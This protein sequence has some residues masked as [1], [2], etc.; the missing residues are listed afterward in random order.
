MEDFENKYQITKTIRFKLEPE[1]KIEN[2]FKNNIKEKDLSL[3]IKQ[4]EELQNKLKKLLHKGK[5]EDCNII[6]NSDGSTAWKCNIEIKYTWM[7]NYLKV[8]F[9]ENLKNTK[10]KHY[11]LIDLK[12]VQEE[13][14]NRWFSET[15]EILNGLKDFQKRVQYYTYEKERDAQAA[16]ILNQFSKRTNFEFIKMFIYSLCNTNN[17]KTD[18]FIEKLKEDIKALEIELNKQKENFLPSQSKGVQFAIGSFNYYTIGKTPKLLEKELQK[19]NEKLNEKLYYFDEKY[20]AYKIKG[21]YRKYESTINVLNLKLKQDKGGI[22]ICNLSL[23]E[24]YKFLKNWKAEQKQNF[25]EAIK[26]NDDN[27][28]KSIE[29]FKSTDDHYETVKKA[30]LYIQKNG[31]KNVSDEIK[32]QIR[33]FFDTF[34]DNPQTPNYKKLCE[35]FRD[36]AKDRGNIVAKI[37][38]IE[39]DKNIAEQLYYWCVII[40]K[41]K[42]KYLYMIPHD[43]NDNLKKAKEYIEKL[44]SDN[45]S[46]TKLHYF[47]SLTLRALRKL[48]FKTKDNTFRGLIPNTVSFPNCEQDWKKE[49]KKIIEFYQQVL[50]NQK[51]INLDFYNNVSKLWENK[52]DTL[53]DFES[54]LNKIC[55]SKK[56]YISNEVENKLKKDFKAISFKITS[57]DIEH[58]LKYG[59]ENYQNKKHTDIWN[60]FWNKDNENN[61]YRVRLNPEVKV[62]W[63]LPKERLILKYGIDSKL[64]DEKKKNR[65]LHEQYTLVTTI[66]SNAY[67]DKINFAFKD[68]FKETNVKETND[69]SKETAINK[70]NENFKYNKFNY[71]IGIDVGEIS[72]A[73]LAV[74]NKE[75]KSQIFEVYEI[76]EEKLNF[77]KKGFLKDGSIREKEYQL[78]QNPSYF[79]N[80]VLYKKTFKEETDEQF[81]NTFKELFNKKTVSG[82]DLTTAKVICDKIILN[83]DFATH[84]RLKELNAKR[85]ISQALK[86]YQNITIDKA[87]DKDGKEKEYALALFGNDKVQI[88]KT[89]KEAIYE[90]KKNYS[91]VKS[92]EEVK[93]ELIKFLNDKQ[94]DDARLEDN[95]NKTRTSLVGNMVGVINFLYKKYPGFIVLE[96]LKQTNTES[97]RRDFEG[98]ITRPL[99]WALYRKFQTEC[100]VPPISELIKLRELNPKNKQNIHQFGII[101]FV[102]E[103]GT[104][105]LCPKCGEKVYNSDMSKD[106]D[107]NKDKKNKVFK[108][109]KCGFNNKT[110]AGEFMGLDTNDTIAA[111]NIAKRGFA[112][113]D[114]KITNKKND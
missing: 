93:E 89:G 82:L 72:L 87:K 10:S 6:K 96:N 15:T 25:I 108:C 79:L 65:Y 11:K 77:S 80:P 47:N 5:K 99:E 71:A 112:N 111:Y 110:D 32:K 22:D 31:K 97:H 66:T 105:L 12:Y 92:F 95:I 107:Y 36:I 57:Q 75:N 90:S 54:E 27:K 29:L 40:E 18:S 39:K 9:Y 60:Y 23:D 101:K 86:E 41:E 69:D 4:I 49:P 100:L 81:N 70:F 52:F 74:I 44:K 19:E 61:N 73:C 28:A 55:Y 56:V 83:G 106:E 78:I 33:D 58:N 21:K 24:V 104:S 3:L 103:K 16:L 17:P 38:A 51:T 64:Y 8:K 34:V 84:Q 35:L 68:T 7:R 85:K 20:K 2:H 1:G 94:L 26:A 91:C 109:G 13:F 59:I 48:C 62:M 45:T 76:K 88:G 46:Q 43:D 114:L 98:D 53:E 50:K 113:L 14:D 67:D 42:Y 102:S 63:R 37:F 30:I